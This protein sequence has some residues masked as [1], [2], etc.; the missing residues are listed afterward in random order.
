MISILKK[1]NY[2]KIL[3]FLIYSLLFY[4]RFI[5]NN[6]DQNFL[7][8][9]D[10]RM[11]LIVTEKISFF[12]NLDPNFYNYGS[13]PFYFLK[14]VSVVFNFLTNAKE[15]GVFH[16]APIARLISSLIDCLIIV[17][18]YFLTKFLFKNKAIALLSSINYGLFFFPIQN[19]NFYI[20]DNFIN[21]FL[22]LFIFALL[23]LVKKFSFTKLILTAF[24]MAGL[25]TTKIT[26]I[27]FLPL[28]FLVFIFIIRKKKNKLWLVS[29]WLVSLTFFCFILMPYGFIKY[30]KFLADTFSQ[31]QMSGNAYVFPYTLQYVNTLPYLYFIK[32]I[33]F[34]GIGPFASFFLLIGLVFFVKNFTKFLYK[35][36]NGR[37]IILYFIFNL[38]YFLIIGRSAV[39]FMR[40]F[41]PLYPFLSICV[42][43]G[44][45][46]VIKKFNKF[47]LSILAI[48]FTL[49]FF[50]CLTFLS[51]YFQDHSR[52][53]ASDWINFKI[54]PHAYIAVEH[55]DDLL[56][57]RN[58]NG[59]NFIQLNL[60]D[61]PDDEIKWLQIKE[62]INQ[63]DYIILSSNRLSKPLQ[64]MNNC[65]KVEKCYL[66]TADYYKKLL[67]GKLNFTLIKRFRN[68]P[69]I[70]I[71]NLDINTDY[72]D[73]SF[74]VYDHPEVLI[75]E[76][77]KS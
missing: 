72:F 38:Y 36:Q 20:V 23:S 7:L 32:D 75:F 55:W 58:E 16:L 3:L 62:K 54:N 35:F 19:S 13:L 2:Q 25:L 53:K 68:S 33:L 49:Q 51:I 5:G 71:F 44:L 69:K 57:L 64:R 31:I 56:P 46:Y 40:Y 73:E 63:A 43:L 41:L 50:Y 39:K 65:Q 67:A 6:Y 10:E 17:T 14:L 48:Y 37:L 52:V 18:I 12:N 45:W 26:P 29:S 27:I 76:K 21:L 22:T 15:V 30:E 11:I 4:F 74:S 47:K 60:Y 66:K 1:Y 34:V 42:G 59:F 77:N 24:I 8:H 9:P 70:P 61:Y 28:F